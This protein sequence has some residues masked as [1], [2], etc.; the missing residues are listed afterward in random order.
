MLSA[1]FIELKS[2]HLVRSLFGPGAS[3]FCFFFNHNCNLSE[4]VQC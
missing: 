3:G 4:N 2:K 1:L